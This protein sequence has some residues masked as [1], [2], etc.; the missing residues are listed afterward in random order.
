MNQNSQ[1]SKSVLVSEHPHQR[2]I[3][4]DN[5]RNKVIVTG[6]RWGKSVLGR[7]EAIKTA[8][9]IKNALVWIVCPTREMAKDIHWDALKRRLKDD[10]KWKIKV[11]ESSLTITRLKTNSKIALKTADNPDRLR[12]R[13]LHKVIIDEFRDMDQSVWSE[14]LRPTLSDYHGQAVFI[15]TT[16]G[17]DVLYDLYLKGQGGDP[18]WKSWTYKTIDSPFISDSEI[19]QARKEL[20]EKT[21]RQEYEASFETATGRVYYAFDRNFNLRQKEHDTNKPVK[22]CLDLNV[23]P[24]KWS[25]VQSHID[26]DYVIGELVKQDTYTLEMIRA[27]IAKYPNAKFIVYGDYTGTNRSTKSP[28]TDYEIIKK[29]IPNCDIRI[30]RT[31]SVLDRI[32]SLNARLCSADGIRHLFVDPKC[33]HTVESL[34][35]TLWKKDKR[36]IDKST[37]QKNADTAISDGLSYY[38]DYEYSLKGKPIV[39]IE[40]AF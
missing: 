18:E 15:S 11:N 32:N 21:F 3:F 9:E 40:N 12:G 13:G 24:C 39:R 4:Y 7:E 29:E 20:D 33:T 26:G 31:V 28:V 5:T 23:N 37:E 27:T 16:N 1:T 19:E 14:V 6:R 22:I 34:E 10:L 30:K 25:F 36:E 17:Y 2:E 38:T 8:F 35:K